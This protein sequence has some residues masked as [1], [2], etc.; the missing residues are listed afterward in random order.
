MAT[1]LNPYLSFKNNAREAMEFYHSIFGGKLDIRTFK[2]YQASQDPHEDDLVMHSV[3]EA[4]NGLVLMASD[5]PERITYQAG[6]N[7]FSLSLSGEDE[8]E[9]SG[10]FT[11]LADGGQITMPLEKALWGDIF[12]MC[13]D[14]FGIAWVVNIAAKPE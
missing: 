1:K 8:P 12:G 10:Y 2:D 5:T 13:T 9:L 4:E 6:V 11:R 3:L 7:D 14:K